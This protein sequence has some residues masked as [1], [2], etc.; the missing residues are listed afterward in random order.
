MLTDDAPT[1]CGELSFRS[2]G[3]GAKTRRSD[4]AKL[5]QLVLA[6]PRTIGLDIR[7]SEGAEQL[8]DALARLVEDAQQ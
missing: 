1:G 6:E 7:V 4:V 8:E 2:V 3:R 5:L